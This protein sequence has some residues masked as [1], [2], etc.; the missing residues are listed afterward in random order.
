M[1]MCKYIYALKKQLLK[2]E[3]MNLKENGDKNMEGFEG[4]KEKGET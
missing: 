1:C 3:A 4:R 2:I